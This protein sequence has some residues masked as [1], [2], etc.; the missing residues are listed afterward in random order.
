M[1]KVL[2]LIFLISF[3]VIVLGEEPFLS[4]SLQT[5][6]PVKVGQ[7]NK[8]KSLKND[9]PR[10][11]VHANLLGFVQLGPVVSVEYGVSRHFVLNAHVRFPFSGRSHKSDI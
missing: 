6:Y 8:P 4:G 1:K 11:A 2:L 10:W 9:F 3:S 5:K 7:N